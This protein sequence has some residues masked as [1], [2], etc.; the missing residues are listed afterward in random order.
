MGSLG[1]PGFGFG[2]APAVP[3]QSDDC[4]AIQSAYVT[5]I[6]PQCKEQHNTVLLPGMPEDVDMP[7]WDDVEK[8][9]WEWFED[10][11]YSA[12]QSILV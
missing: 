5:P 12:R 1:A 8:T 9:M 6:P 2:W 10:G 7:D 3:F 4:D 11:A